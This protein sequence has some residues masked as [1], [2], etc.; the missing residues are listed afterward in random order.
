[1]AFIPYSCQNIS[2]DD[3]AAVTAVLRSEYLTQGPSGPAFE[4]AFAE[5]HKVRHAVAVSSATAALHIGCLALAIGPGSLVWTSPNSFIASAN[6]A[7]YCGADVD[8]VDI[9]PVTRNMS[10]SALTEKLAAADKAGRLPDMVIPVDFAGFAVDLKEMRELAD[11]YGFKILEDASHATGAS[12]LGEPVGSA[13]AHATVFSFHAVKVV[14]T[15]EGGMITTNDDDLA[16]KFRLLRSHGMTREPDQMEGEPEGGW[17]YE[18]VALGYNYRLTDLQSALGLSQLDRLDQWQR[19]RAEIADRYDRLFAGMPLRL[20]ARLQ[21]RESA[22]H[23]YAI[24]L[25]DDVAASRAD[26][27]AGMRQAGIGVNVHYIPIHTQPQYRRLGFE[28]GDFA[29]AERYYDRAISI[30]LFPAMTDEQQQKVVDAV[31]GL[32]G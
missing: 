15:A 20:P 19:R 18:Q 17:Y 27:F 29:N 5:R 1:M 11:C 23:L 14:T 2:D 8:F 16:R 3:I 28:R 7:L 4:K 25:G 6:C 9:D 31:R 12:Y 24:E 21:D 22:W 10:L 30:P 26:V 13:Y 32:I